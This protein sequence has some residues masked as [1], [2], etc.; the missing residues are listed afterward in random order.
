VGAPDTEEDVVVGLPVPLNAT[1]SGE[2]VAL[3]VTVTL[4]VNAP[5]L[6]GVKVAFSEAVFPGA[7]TCPAEIPVALN[8]A[9]DTL[10]FEIVTFEFPLLVNVTLCAL[11]LP[12]LTLPKLKLVGLALSESVAALTVSV[13]TLLVTLPALLLTD[14]VKLVPLSEVVSAAVV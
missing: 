14:T 10:T 12:T 4:P 1:A 8:P 13:A 7:T 9:P 5:L 2:F 6:A 3:L 11:L